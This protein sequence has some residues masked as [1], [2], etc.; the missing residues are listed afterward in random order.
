MNQN[1]EDVYFYIDVSK[2]LLKRKY[3]T[4]SIEFYIKNKRKIN[5]KGRYGA[6]LFQEEG[7][8]IF[9]TD[10]KDSEVIIN[11]IEENWKS[12][13]KEKS[14]F[15]NGL[16]YIFSYISETVR[17][18]PKFYRIIVITDTPSDLSEEYQE[19]L[20][21]LVSKIKI[22]PT[23]IDIIRIVEEGKRF[24]KDDVKLNVLANDTKGG[25]FYVQHKHEF[26]DVI[27]KL[28]K[29]K[30]LINR[31]QYKEDEIHI[32]E[33][34]YNF[35][36]KLAKKLKDPEDMENLYCYFCKELI[37]PVCADINDVPLVCEECGSAFHH[38]CITNYI[39]E[40]NIGIPNIFRC[41]ECHILLQIEERE[42]IEIRDM[43]TE[44]ESVKEF[45][46]MNKP[47]EQELE[48][49]PEPKREE[50]KIVGV[51]PIKKPE[52]S[53]ESD[54]VSQDPI[55]EV[56]PEPLH[57]EGKVVKKVRV[58]GFFGKVY[59][60]RKV[61]GKVIYRTASQSSTTTQRQ[62]AS[63]RGRMQSKEGVNYWSPS[64][65]DETDEEKLDIKICPICGSQL[66]GHEDACPVC[67][68]NLDQ[69]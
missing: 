3:I 38:C 36:R 55:R 43:D 7:N 26:H 31:F 10:K 37:C 44:L 29:N 67:G 28:V 60:I 23:F 8:P 19:A 66:K 25:I 15:E 56:P 49:I 46:G 13:P 35:Y 40:H 58:G 52:K 9:I 20:F 57:E 22:F 1:P 14:Y 45:M 59:I 62:K 32:D 4:R 11:A 21:S 34:D 24:F 39:S 61:N 51:K 68:S 33:D 42:V 54:R 48:P 5:P 41:P 64:A 16:F 17:K 27:K 53:F 6:L 50:P 65:Q 47:K 2:K 18:K 12:R 63:T 30:Q 69:F